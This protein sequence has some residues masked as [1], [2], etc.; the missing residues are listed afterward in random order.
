MWTDKG[1][2]LLL[3]I[4][5]SGKTRKLL[6]KIDAAISTN[7]KNANLRVAKGAVLV[8]Q[9]WDEQN[10]NK[11]IALSTKADA[12]FDATLEVD[13]YHWDAWMTKA[14]FYAEA[15]EKQY[16]NQA[17]KLFKQLIDSQEQY[18]QKPHYVKAYIEY[19]KLL[20]KQG[21]VKEAAK[22]YRRGQSRFPKDKTLTNLLKK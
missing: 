15:G 3:Q 11:I 13:P 21:K 5:S 22:V 4:Y 18:Q 12:E 7:P 14:A 16:E 20:A 10:E 9:T 1:E 17:A 6:Q 8:T 19:G 2:Q